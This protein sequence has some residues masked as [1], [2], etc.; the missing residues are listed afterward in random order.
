MTDIWVFPVPEAL[1]EQNPDEIHYNTGVL[2]KS[3]TGASP[4]YTVLGNIKIRCIEYDDIVVDCRSDILQAYDV[5]GMYPYAEFQKLSK[6]MQERVL[7]KCTKW[8][9]QWS[10]MFANDRPYKMPD[11]NASYGYAKKEL[12]TTRVKEQIS[13]SGIGAKR[14]RDIEVLHTPQAKKLASDPVKLYFKKC[15]ECEH[16]PV[17]MEEGERFRQ[18]K[19]TC[20]SPDVH[21]DV[22]SAL[23]GRSKTSLTCLSCNVDMCD[24]CQGKAGAVRERDA[25]AVRE[26]DAGA[27]SAAS[28]R[29]TPKK[30]ADFDDIDI[31]SEMSALR[32]A[33][34]S[35]VAAASLAPSSPAAPRPKS[36]DPYIVKG[37]DP[38]KDEINN[39]LQQLL[40]SIEPDESSK[41]LVLDH[42][43]DPRSAKA[44]FAA[45]ILEV[46]TPNPHYEFDVKRD[47]VKPGTVLVRQMQTAL[48]FLKVTSN[49]YKLMYLDYTGN[50]GT[51]KSD[52]KP[53]LQ[54]LDTSNKGAIFAITLC[55][56]RSGAE[57]PD[58]IKA[59]VD[60]KIEEL[61]LIGKPL[62]SAFYKGK[63]MTTC[64]W[65][66]KNA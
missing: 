42:P 14:R 41:V 17:F 12:Q 48:E 5:R 33:S 8:A 52:I 53:A 34:S 10:Q 2:Q 51:H 20:V 59:F 4:Y 39:T 22:C 65:L 13:A 46:H 66:V 55:T 35:P 44:M 64:Y 7:D 58:V 15:F 47:M 37:D 43:K 61:G 16:D 9:P 40:P 62:S 57:K 45:G 29:A 60:A 27:A 54:A 50:F 28:K 19:A 23:I 21:C 30:L 1:R 11:A 31:V 3:Y 32:S 26:R 38:T 49:K 56:A 36:P 18:A 25:G 24:K 63:A 6:R